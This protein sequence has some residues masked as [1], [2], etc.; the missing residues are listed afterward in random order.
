[1]AQRSHRG[2]EKGEKRKPS[3]WENEGISITE[4]KLSLWHLVRVVTAPAPT[5]LPQMTKRQNE[6]KKGSRETTSSS[7]GPEN[8]GRST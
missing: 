1:M 7:T 6:E 4:K 8:L 2:R 3:Q 5:V